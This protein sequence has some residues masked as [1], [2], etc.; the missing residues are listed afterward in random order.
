MGHYRC[1]EPPLVRPG[2][3][4]HRSSRASRSRWAK[5]INDQVGRKPA[6]RKSSD[7]RGGSDCSRSPSPIAGERSDKQGQQSAVAGG[8]SGPATNS[9]AL[10]A[11]N[12][13]SKKT[14]RI[15]SSAAVVDLLY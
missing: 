15:S 1:F 13:A 10:A 2:Q 14:S 11:R 9:A 4:I 12:R 8:K 3:A 6:I 5:V 7:A